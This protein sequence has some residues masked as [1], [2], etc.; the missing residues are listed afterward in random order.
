MI[1]SQSKVKVFNGRV[2]VLAARERISQSK[3]KVLM[4]A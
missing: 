3:D 2:D 1:I 4:G